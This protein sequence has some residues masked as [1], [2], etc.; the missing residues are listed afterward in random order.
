MS[1]VY[2]IGSDEEFREIPGF[3]DYRIGSNGTVISRKVE[4]SRKIGPWRK[5]A[6]K[7]WPENKYCVTTLL[8]DLRKYKTF[9][10]HHLVLEAFVGPRP[11][12]TLGRHLN[13]IPEDNKASN[14]AWG[15]TK[16][17]YEDA[18][19]NKRINV[20]EVS[21]QAKLTNADVAEIRRLAP[22]MKYRDIG[23]KYGLSEK[24]VAGIVCRSRWKHVQ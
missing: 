17:N 19:A 2:L 5:M 3:S 1:E 10:I 20:G 7:H 14:L 12:G 22:T 23:D 24:Y 4:R 13:D 21:Y 15:T 8:S 6:V 11:E 18:L 9:L 16:D